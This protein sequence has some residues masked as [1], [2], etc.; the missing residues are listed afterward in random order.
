MDKE[1]T[2]KSNKSNKTNES[3]EHKGVQQVAEL[4]QTLQSTHTDIS[5]IQDTLINIMKEG[6]KEFVRENKR[7]MTYLEMRQLYG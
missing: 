2:N 3:I 5:V 4:M 6:E 7:T 1:E